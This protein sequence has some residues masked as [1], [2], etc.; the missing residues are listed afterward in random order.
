MKIEIMRCLVTCLVCLGVMILAVSKFNSQLRELSLNQQQLENNCAGIRQ[1]IA[2]ELGVSIPNRPVRTF[3][4][5]GD[6]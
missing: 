5:R 6:R 2:K 4:E 3:S 1:V